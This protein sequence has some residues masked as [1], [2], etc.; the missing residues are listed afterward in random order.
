MK[1]I[2]VCDDDDGISEVIKVIL[3][4]AGYNV[5][6][7]NNGR[8]IQKKITQF[9]PNLVLLDLWMP[10]IDGK[11]ITKILKKDKNF[12]KIPI[13]VVSAL[14]DTRKI[15]LDCGADDFLS[16]PFE[17]NSLLFMVKKYTS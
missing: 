6:V 10:G 2:L 4:G 12:S 1:K 5:G 15:A 7:L 13:I 17:M 14:N 8:S 9:K 16:K 11:E 3:E